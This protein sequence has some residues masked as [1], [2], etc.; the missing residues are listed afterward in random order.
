MYACLQCG[1]RLPPRAKGGH[2][3]REYCS[4]R[5]RQ[6]AYRK[7]TKQRQEIER[8][9]EGVSWL[10][11]PDPQVTRDRWRYERAGLLQRCK[12]LMAEHATGQAELKL[13]RSKNVM[14]EES[15]E[16]LRSLLADKEAEIIR[17]GVLLESNATKRTR[18]G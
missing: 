11:P 15:I 17:L 7:Q 3:E 14:L 18:R 10:P 6:R 4:D 2:R 13:L 8:L 9:I 1:K 16:N 12:L 5:C